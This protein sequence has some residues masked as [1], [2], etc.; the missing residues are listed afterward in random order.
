MRTDSVHEVEAGARN[1]VIIYVLSVARVLSQRNTQSL[2]VQSPQVIPLGLSHL[3][4][5]VAG[6]M[7]LG[8]LSATLRMSGL[9]S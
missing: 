2:I 7:L 3:R 4:L 1:V 8:L 5:L 9:M 6:L